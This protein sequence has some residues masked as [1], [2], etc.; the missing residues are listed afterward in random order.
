MLSFVTWNALAAVVTRPRAWALGLGVVLLGIA[1]MVLI[2]ANA[3]AGQAPK[4]VPVDSGSARADV[5]GRQFPGGDRAPLLLVVTR[6]DGA[7]LIPGD[8]SEVQAARD[9]MQARRGSSA[10]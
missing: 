6:R 4:S 10:R 5:L 8:L 1:S 2:G 9:R 3:S 7:S